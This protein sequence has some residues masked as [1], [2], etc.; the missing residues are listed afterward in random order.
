M[1]NP[2]ERERSTKK[3]RNRWLDD[4]YSIE[5]DIHARGGSN[6]HIRMEIISLISSIVSNGTEAEL[7]LT[8]EFL[9]SILKG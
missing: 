7:R 8:M 6:S 1:S 5:N 4:L 9:H 2:V 3:K